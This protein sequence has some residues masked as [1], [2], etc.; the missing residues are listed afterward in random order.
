MNTM[1]TLD[2][3]HQTIATLTKEKEQATIECGKLF[4]ERDSLLAQ[5]KALREAIESLRKFVTSDRDL[6]Q[7]CLD[8]YSLR[9]FVP[10]QHFARGQVD[11]FKGVLNRIENELQAL[12]AT[13]EQPTTTLDLQATDGAKVTREQQL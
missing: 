1:T 11:A 9:T 4:A 3:L 12:N 13:T 5:N 8:T 7:E 6:S 2:S 10:Q